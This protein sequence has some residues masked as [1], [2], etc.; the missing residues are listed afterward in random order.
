MKIDKTGW[1]KLY[2]EQYWDNAP[3]IGR[4]SQIQRRLALKRIYEFNDYIIHQSYKIITRKEDSKKFWA[5]DHIKVCGFKYPTN[6]KRFNQ[7]WEKNKDFWDYCH[8]FYN[9]EDFSWNVVADVERKAEEE[10]R[11]RG[12]PEPEP[13]S[14]YEVIKRYELKGLKLVKQPTM[15]SQT[16]KRS[17]DY[18][19]SADPNES[20]VIDIINEEIM[21]TVANFPQFGNRLNSISETGDGSAGAYPFRFDNFSNN[22]IEYNFDTEED[23]YIVP[24]TNIDPYSGIW[25]LQFG[26]A[27]GVPEDVINKG[28][29]FKVM[30]TILQITNDFINRFKP[31]RLQFKPVK[32]E[33][34]DDDKRRFKLYMQY[35]KKN[36]RN[37][38]MVFEYGDY[39]VI[40]RKV[41]IKSTTPRL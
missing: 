17:D 30:G 18:K 28:R 4:S 41:K 27:G 37:D 2:E 3:G 40:E 7:E 8:T 21:T 6:L 24:I 10:G 5:T 12:L 22:E 16:P 13:L 36:M 39:I 15:L 33:E 11:K 9:P 35:I 20:K 19:D 23:D 32:D 29:V 25:E 26:V 31:N 1:V 14:H 38:Y 34:R